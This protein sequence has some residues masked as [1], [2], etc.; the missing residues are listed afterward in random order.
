M[1][2]QAFTRLTALTFALV[3]VLGI[4]PAWAGAVKGDPS[5]SLSGHQPDWSQDNDDRG[6]NDPNGDPDNPTVDGPL[7]N[8]T[9]SPFRSSIEAGG[10]FSGHGKWAAAHSWLTGLLQLIW[11]G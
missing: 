10:G 6:N 3:L 8:S 2:K 5:G 11:G 9:V 7:E 4:S 1:S